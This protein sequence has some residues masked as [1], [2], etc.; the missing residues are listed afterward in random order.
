[1]E[2][3]DCVDLSRYIERLSLAL[4]SQNIS[5]TFCIYLQYSTPKMKL[6]IVFRWQ[7]ISLISALFLFMIF[8]YF[9]HL[10]VYTLCINKENMM[11]F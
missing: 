4:F 2:E 1:M 6:C 9:T 8:I 3:R 5:P 7:R 10:Y 11:E